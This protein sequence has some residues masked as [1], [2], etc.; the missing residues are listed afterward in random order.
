MQLTANFDKSKSYHTLEYGNHSISTEQVQAVWT[1]RFWEPKLSAELDPKYQQACVRESTATL[2]GF[3][4]SL[5]DAHWVDDLE[6]INYANN[7]LRQLRVASEVGFDIPKTLITNKAE[8]A[9]DFFPPSQRENSEQAI[10]C[11]FSW[12][13]SYILVFPLHQYRQ[14]GRFT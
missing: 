8:A 6:R 12:Y 3:W 9:R 5:K 11:S 10:N 2:N 7:K 1:R 4:D 13:G 14:R